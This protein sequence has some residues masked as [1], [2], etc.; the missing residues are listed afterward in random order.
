MT[1]SGG[2]MSS[3]D[4]VTGRSQVMRGV[5]TSESFVLGM[6]IWESQHVL[7]TSDTISWQNCLQCKHEGGVTG[8]D[9]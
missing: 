1:E 9:E 4:G 5:F 6:I 8:D 7:L 2:H 3:L